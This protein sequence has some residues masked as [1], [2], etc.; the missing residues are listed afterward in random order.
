[1]RRAPEWG[2]ALVCGIAY[3][4]VIWCWPGRDRWR[5]VPA[6]G[7]GGAG[8]GAGRVV[9]LARRPGAGLPRGRAHADGAARRGVGV[10][11]GRVRRGAAVEYRLQ[12]LDADWPRLQASHQARLAR[13]LDRGMDGLIGRTRLAAE[14]AAERAAAPD[15]GDMFAALGEIR[16]R[17]AVA[18]IA[19]FDEAGE[20]I[21]W[22]GEHRGALPREAKLGDGTVFYAERPLFG[23]L[24]VT[25]PVEGRGERVVAAALL[26]TGLVMEQQGAVGFAD[27]FAEQMGARPYFAAGP[28]P[29]GAWSWSPGRT[30][31]CTRFEPISRAEWRSGVAQAGRRTVVPLALLSLVFL[32]VVWLRLG[33][34]RGRGHGAPL[35]GSRAR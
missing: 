2:T 6:C 29:E 33:R 8:R 17:T 19:L 15:R 13:E 7:R 1:M 21:A 23:Y 11:R 10:A 3:A 24:Y 28:G 32:S 34:G 25:R 18:A 20:L 30:R 9:A 12:R 27:R 26:Q 14:R 16:A 4:A 35:S 5:V 22:A 31:C